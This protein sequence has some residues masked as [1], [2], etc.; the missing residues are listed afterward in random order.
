MPKLRALLIAPPGAGKGTQ[1]SRICAHFDVTHIS[2]GDLFRAAVASGSDLGRLV[3]G[4]LD[5]GDLVPDDVVGL[6]VREAVVVAVKSTGGYLLDGFPRTVAQAEAAHTLATELG[7]AAQ[8]VLTFVVPRPVLLERLMGRGASEG[9]SDDDEP[10]IR[11]RLSVYDQA[12]APLL[13]YYEG[14]GVLVRVDAD[15]PVDE[16]TAASIAVLEASLAVHQDA[17]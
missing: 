1:A 17:T 16:V 6:T 11:H 13:D 2:T 4:Y 7:I 9:R 3:A 14:L 12:T 10:T 5:R 8:A 15:R